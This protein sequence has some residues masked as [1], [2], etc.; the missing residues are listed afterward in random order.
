MKRPAFISLLILISGRILGTFLPIPSY[1]CLTG[2]L[3]LLASEAWLLFRRDKAAISGSGGLLLFAILFLGLYQQRRIVEKDCTSGQIAKTLSE[4]PFVTIKGR[5][6]DEP[7][8]YRNVCK[9]PV[10]D[11]HLVQDGVSYPINT[12]ALVFVYGEVAEGLAGKDPACGDFIT[13]SA[14][15]SIPP[16]FR[17]PTLFNYR[18]WLRL[19]GIHIVFRINR[20]SEV[21]ISPPPDGRSIFYCIYH[22]LSHLRANADKNFSANLSPKNAATL[23]G[24]TSSVTHDISREEREDFLRTGLVHL[25]AVSGLHVGMFAIFILFILNLAHLHVRTVSILTVIFIWLFCAY[26]GFRTPVVRASIM[27]TC[28]LSSYW[29]PGL[30]RPL[31][32]LSL[33]SFAAFWTL[34]FNPRALFQM[35]F[36]FSYACVYAIII[37]MPFFKNHLM[38]NLERLPQEKKGVHARINRFVLRP[39]FTVISIQIALLPLMAYYYHRIS[40]MALVANIVTIPLAFLCLNGGILMITLGALFPAILP[41]LGGMTEIVLNLLRWVVQQLSHFPFTMLHLPSLPWIMVGVYYGALLCGNWILERREWRQRRKIAFILTTLFLAALL[42]WFPI[43]WRSEPDVEVVFLDVGQGDSTYVEF[44]GGTNMLIDSGRGYPRDM[45]AEVIS[46]FLERRGIDAIDVVVITHPDADHTGGLPSVFNRFFVDLLIEGGST[47][48]SE[49]NETVYQKAREWG[50]VIKSVS[51]GDKLTG[52][53][54][55]E[56]LVLNPPRPTPETWND[57]N[58]S[59]VLLLKTRDAGFLFTGDAEAEAERNMWTSGVDLHAAVLKVGHHGSRTATSEEFIK[60][61]H[62]LMAVISAGKGNI[63]HHPHAEVL[64]RLK[65]HDIRVYR[66]DEQGAITMQVRR[67]KVITATEE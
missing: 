67:G 12:R 65:A 47:S 14:R 7:D 33:I 2:I 52:F 42:L 32:S 22:S 9:F 43:L 8:F 35:D 36:Q 24:L 11:L 3:F 30:R 17:N 50:I 58:R 56:M 1:L 15:A 39:L 18:A 6:A 25:F 28:L 49:K 51:R 41:F 54:G 46:E 37:F 5:L 57:N 63:Y 64:N 26:V 10:R 60:S 4:R 27:V 53:D 40:I 66:T 29:L 55:A 48:N 59:V 38:F 62:P 20:N 19:Q 23:K 31:E 16:T 13:I 61:V 34:I 21:K 44:A 45:G